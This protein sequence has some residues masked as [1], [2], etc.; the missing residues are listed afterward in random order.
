MEKTTIEDTG[1]ILAVAK[2]TAGQVECK[3][4]LTVQGMN[5]KTLS[6]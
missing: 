1:D 6:I 4:Q 2:N 5:S 3:C